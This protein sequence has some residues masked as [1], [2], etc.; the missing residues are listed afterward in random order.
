M[1]LRE[2]NGNDGDP[3]PTATGPRVPIRPPSVQAPYDIQFAHLQSQM[4]ALSQQ[5]LSMTPPGHTG[6]GYVHLPDHHQ[7]LFTQPP[8]PNYVPRPPPLVTPTSRPPQRHAKRRDPRN[9]SSKH[10][11]Y[12]VRNGLHGNDV[13][14][15]WPQASKYCWNQAARTFLPGSSCRGFPSYDKAWEYLLGYPQESIPFDYIKQAA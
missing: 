8:H 13:Y 1:S 7:P 14:S 11:F 2:R 6:D 10:S 15:S 12:A 3:P 4:M 5:V 9:E